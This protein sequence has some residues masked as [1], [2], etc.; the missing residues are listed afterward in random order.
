MPLLAMPMPPVRSTRTPVITIPRHDAA[1]AALPT[2]S[3]GCKPSSWPTRAPNV[4][5]RSGS[6]SGDDWRSCSADRPRIRA[7]ANGYHRAFGC[8]SC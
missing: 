5:V 8:F 6:R 4:K 2:R 7:P 3:R 1:K